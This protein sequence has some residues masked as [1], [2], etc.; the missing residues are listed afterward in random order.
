VDIEQRLIFFT[1]DDNNR[2]LRVEAALE[3]GRLRKLVDQLLANAR[4]AGI[5]VIEAANEEEAKE[6]LARTNEQPRTDRS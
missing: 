1:D 3:I 5:G 6:K 2:N 4:Q